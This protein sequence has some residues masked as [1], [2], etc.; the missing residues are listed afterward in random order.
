MGNILRHRPM[1][2][3][4]LKSRGAGKHFQVPPDASPGSP[5]Y[6]PFSIHA[7]FPQN[8]PVPAAAGHPVTLEFPGAPWS[9]LAH[10]AEEVPP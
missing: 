10:P 5:N 7:L 6:Y 9:C 1:G 2:T 3:I 8:H 4:L